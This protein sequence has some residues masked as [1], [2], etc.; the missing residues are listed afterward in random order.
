MVALHEVLMKLEGV[1]VEAELAVR[2]NRASTRNR[3][4]DLAI[5]MRPSVRIS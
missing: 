2:A 5:A 4:E 1:V 3:M